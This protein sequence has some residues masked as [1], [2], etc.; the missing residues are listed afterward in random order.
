LCGCTK[1]NN[2]DVI[3]DLKARYLGK[4]FDAPWYIR[5]TDRYRDLQMEIFTNEIGKFAKKHEE[6]LLHHVNVEAIYL[7]DKVN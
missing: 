7:L 3:Q 4:I 5:N 1:Q 2:T 6:R